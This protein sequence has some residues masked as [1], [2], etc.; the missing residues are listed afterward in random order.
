MSYVTGSQETKMAATAPEQCTMKNLMVNKKVK[1]R[2][3]YVGKKTCAEVGLGENVVLDLTRSLIGSGCHIFMDNFF[4]SPHLLQILHSHGL[5]GTGT[6]RKNRTGL[7]ET[8]LDRDMKKGEILS[9]QTTDKKMNFTKWMDT[10]AVHLISN[11]QR[12]VGTISTGRRQKGS[13]DKAIIAVPEIVKEYNKYM[14][15]VDLADQLKSYYAVDIR[16]RY[17][18]YLRVV[19]DSL[20]TTVVNGYLNY[21]SLNP[22]TKVTHLEFRQQVVHGLLG[23]YTS[24]KNTFPTGSINRKAAPAVIHDHLPHIMPDRKRCKLCHK[25]GTENRSRFAC[26]TCGA[27]LCLQSDRNCFTEFHT[28]HA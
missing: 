7:P 11:S 24:R 10:K 12:S 26:V 21:K 19:F 6:V 18:Y 28:E 15:G 22:D 2:K 14:G 23:T 1:E 27:A 9:F 16:C 8:K 20:D 13:T 25:R 3:M 5:Q 4:T 17:K